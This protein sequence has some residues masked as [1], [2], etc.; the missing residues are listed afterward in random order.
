MTFQP[1]PRNL[2]SAKSVV[3][4]FQETGYDPEGY[5]LYTYAAFQVWQAAADAAGTTDT[6][7]VSDAIRG[8][9]FDTLIGAPPSDEQ[10][11]V[12]HPVYVRTICSHCSYKPQ[13]SLQPRTAS[14]PHTPPTPQRR[15]ATG[16]T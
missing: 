2:E 7:A 6:K 14:R 16:S 1:D 8:K 4:K 5:T 3:A 11:A 15:P 12:Q 9:T 13:V 10:V